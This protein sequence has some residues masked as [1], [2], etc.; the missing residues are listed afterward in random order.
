VDAPVAAAERVPVSVAVGVDAAVAEDTAVPVTVAVGVDAAV[1][2]LVCVAVAN[3][4]PIFAAVRVDSAEKVR[5]LVEE[6]VTVV[7]AVAELEDRG[8]AVAVAVAVEVG[9]A[10]RAADG[11]ATP[12]REAVAEAQLLAR[13]VTVAAPVCVGGEEGVGEQ[14][15]A[16]TEEPS[17]HAVVQPQGKGA[18]APRGQKVPAGHTS[19]PLSES[20]CG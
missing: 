11:V 16:F 19:Q 6:P 9:V 7:T 8:V 5:L 18:A 13:E 3:A 4:E 10:V 20:S 17:G 2:L 14:L 1:A 12:V 15:A